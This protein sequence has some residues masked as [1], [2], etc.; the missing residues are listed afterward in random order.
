TGHKQAR[1]R[2]DDKPHDQQDDD[3]GNH[4]RMTSRSI[5]DYALKRRYIW[6]ARSGAQMPLPARVSRRPAA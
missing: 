4:V 5:A 3:E 2:A 6:I 1:D